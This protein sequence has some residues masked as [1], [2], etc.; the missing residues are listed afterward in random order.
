MHEAKIPLV[1]RTESGNRKEPWCSDIIFLLWGQGCEHRV[2]RENFVYSHLINCLHHA[3]YKAEPKVWTPCAQKKECTIHFFPYKKSRKSIKWKPR[4]IPG[5]DANYQTYYSY[6]M[7]KARFSKEEWQ[8]T[9]IQYCI[10]HFTIKFNWSSSS[11][12]PVSIRVMVIKQGAYV[13]SSFGTEIR[14]LMYA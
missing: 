14:N 12:S 13:L 5:R 10:I 9:F 7:L 4:R 8:L 11:T 6:V 1:N 3:W 2:S